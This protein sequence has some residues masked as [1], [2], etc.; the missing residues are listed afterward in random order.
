MP[1]ANND[2][3]SP[4][5]NGLLSIYDLGTTP[6]RIIPSGTSGDSTEDILVIP[7]YADCTDTTNLGGVI[8]GK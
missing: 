2:I 6:G 3:Y 4:L 8:Y 7:I 5:E 1:S